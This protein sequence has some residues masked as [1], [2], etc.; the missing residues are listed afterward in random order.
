MK[1]QELRKKVGEHTHTSKERHTHTR[2]KR[3]EKKEASLMLRKD[4]SS[5]NVE[6]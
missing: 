1:P 6:R 4:L 2:E 3:V 5:Y